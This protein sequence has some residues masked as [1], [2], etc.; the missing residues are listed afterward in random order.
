MGIDWTIIFSIG[1]SFGA[2]STA[3]YFSH[4]LTLKREDEKYKKEKY[5]KFYSPLVF[6]IIKYIEAE[7]SKISKVNQSI[8]PDPDL[9]FATIITTIEKNIQ[10]ADSDFIKIYEEAKTSEMIGDL[11]EDD[12]M[13][14]FFGYGK[15]DSHLNA[16]EQFFTDYLI[17]SKDLEILSSKVERE[18]KESI[19]VIKLY[20]MFDK[21]SFL[22]TAKMLFALGKHIVAG[23]D[24][25]GFIKKLNDLDEI[26][27]INLK[28]YEQT[29]DAIHDECYDELFALLQF[30]K[31]SPV[32]TITKLSIK[33]TLK[34]DISFINGNLNRKINIS[35]MDDFNI[36]DTVKLDISFINGKIN[37]SGMDDLNT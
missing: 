27:S 12:S 8:N 16:F 25:D 23:G 35:R 3:Q 9:I 14:E 1:G 34:E 4:R 22:R 24:M 21:Y 33:D 20:K 13:R 31:K 15:F 26:T 5:Q 18:V 7:G 10:Y 19:A 37:I 30:I 6:K 17:I 32:F 36:E 29:G 28:P 11:D 2:A